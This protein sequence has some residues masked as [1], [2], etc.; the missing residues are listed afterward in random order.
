MRQTL[1]LLWLVRLAAPAWALATA[2]VEELPP[3]KEEKS[4]VVKSE[5]TPD[6]SQAQG[7]G[8]I[9]PSGRHYSVGASALADYLH[10]GQR[11]IVTLDAEN[12]ASHS[13]PDENFLYFRET[14]TGHRW[15]IA[16]YPSGDQRYRVYFQSADSPGVWQPFQRSQLTWEPQLDDE[17]TVVW[18]W[19]EPSCG[20]SPMSE[21][22][23]IEP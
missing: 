23:V 22:M 12:P 6:R 17:L 1:L 3:P 21:T 9:G 4:V 13:T 11:H 8:L 16:R 14:R 18:T 10:R 20:Q 19:P 2:P 7:W 15:A 5:P